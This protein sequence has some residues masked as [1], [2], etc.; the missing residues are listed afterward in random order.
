MRPGTLFRGAN[1]FVRPAGR[2]FSYTVGVRVAV[3]SVVCLLGSW[4]TAQ[5]A[6]AFLK[7][8]TESDFAAIKIQAEQ[9]DLEAQFQVALAY[10]YGSPVPR[11]D[12]SASQ[13]MQKSAGGGF[14]SAMANLGLMYQEGRGVPEDP[15]LALEWMEKAAELH[16]ADGEFYL[17]HT[18]ER[19]VGV[20]RDPAKAVEWYKRA[21]ADG[22]IPVSVNLG[23]MYLE[24][25][26]VK[27]DP[28]EAVRLFRIGA[29][30]GLAKAQ[31]NL[32][33]MYYD[34]NG[35]D[36]DYD[37]AV[38]WLNRA[39]DQ[40]AAI[41]QSN[42]GVLYME[43]RG[44]PRDTIEAYKWFLLARQEDETAG[45]AIALLNRELS[46]VQ[47]REGER[48]AQVWIRA[49]TAAGSN[50]ADEILSAVEESEQ[51]NTKKPE[52]TNSFPAPQPQ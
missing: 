1:A 23:L 50:L 39:A 38:M 32:G 19:G 6:P 43:G 37:Q 18:Y 51:K 21:L 35:V 9:G 12:L 49:H 16:N 5:E 3:L 2:F 20:A 29:E 8:L 36:Q 30:A 34:G 22:N 31:T 10:A 47:R 24:G 17:A 15:K 7:D 45:R 28:R 40:G 25:D 44:V 14:A 13:W 33:R 48:R 42:M 41:A 26:G 46:M 52:N 11:N 27:K 4:A